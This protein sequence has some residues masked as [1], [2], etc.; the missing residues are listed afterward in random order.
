MNAILNTMKSEISKFFLFEK[1]VCSLLSINQ[2]DFQIYARNNGGY[3]F[4]LRNWIK[5]SYNDGSTV[6]EVV[7]TIKESK[8]ISDELSSFR[9]NRNN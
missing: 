9:P 7:N 6:I 4:L 8:F 2:C 1:K 3:I 5:E